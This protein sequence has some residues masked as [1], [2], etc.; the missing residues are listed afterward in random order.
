MKV[1]TAIWVLSVWKGINVIEDQL[2]ALGS[3]FSLDGDKLFV[4]LCIYLAQS[5]TN[6]CNSYRKRQQCNYVE[7]IVLFKWAI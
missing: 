1:E 4:N 6:E 5:M 7:E 2:I 3:Y